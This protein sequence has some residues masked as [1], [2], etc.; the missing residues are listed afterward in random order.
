VTVDTARTG[1]RA[2]G[3]ATALD[4][5]FR[6][7]WSVRKRVEVTVLGTLAALV[8]WLVYLT[9]RVS[10]LDEADV[11]ARHRRGERFVFSTWHDGLIL[12]PL[13]LRH[14]RGE[15]RPRVLISWHRDAEIGAQAARWFGARFVRGSTTRGGIG[16]IRGLLTAFRDGEDVVVVS[17]GP[18]GPRHQAKPGIVQLG[19]AT[20]VPVVPVVLSVAPCRR[21]RSWDRMQVPIPFGRVAIRFGEPVEVGVDER[22][23]QA[24]L[25]AAMDTGTR[26]VERAL[27]A[28]S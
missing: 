9:L 25:Q 26:E 1:E 21:L 8:L 2:R 6:R 12:L 3:A 20:H 13:V 23:G 27:G 7:R 19:R 24:R 28:T 22:E 14:A 17:D 15:F 5:S 11:L 4:S 18:R 10:W 16:A